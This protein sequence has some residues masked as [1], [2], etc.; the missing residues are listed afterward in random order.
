MHYKISSAKYR[1]LLSDRIVYMRL[2]K[3]VHPWTWKEASALKY[4][5][6]PLYPAGSCVSWEVYINGYIFLWLLLTYSLARLACVIAQLIINQLLLSYILSSWIE[7]QSRWS[8]LM[9]YMGNGAHGMT[10][11]AKSQPKIVKVC[12]STNQIIPNQ[13]PL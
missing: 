13:Q 8:E 12:Y 5:G 10:R 1:P 11:Y 4:N 6:V 3:R 2:E 7:L 9:R